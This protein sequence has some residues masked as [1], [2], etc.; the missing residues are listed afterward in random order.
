MSSSS[1]RSVFIASVHSPHSRPY[2]FIQKATWAKI[3]RKQDA[4]CEIKTTA[5]FNA[6]YVRIHLREGSAT[7]DHQK[8]KIK[9]NAVKGA[10]FLR[11]VIVQVKIDLR[12]WWWC[13]I[14]RTY[15][16]LAQDSVRDWEIW[17]KFRIFKQR[18]KESSGCTFP[19]ERA[20]D[21]FMALSRLFPTVWFLS[22]MIHRLS[23]LSTVRIWT[24]ASSTR[25][26]CR[27]EKAETLASLRTC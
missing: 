13:A 14:L 17:G 12:G 16:A 6:C 15:V 8:K 5:T 7:G 1:S 20:R 21:R 11:T 24:L 19:K 2:S 25:P 27:G 9:T 26:L 18:N 22:C 23:H 4:A 3:A 10:L